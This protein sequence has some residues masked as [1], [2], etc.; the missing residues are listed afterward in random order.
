MILA[1][2]TPVTAIAAG[3][4]TDDNG[5]VHESDID[6]LASLGITRGCNPPDNDHFCPN[7]PVT[8]GQMAAFLNRALELPAGSDGEFSDTAGSVFVADINT[9]AAADITRGCNPPAN[10]RFCPNDPVTRGQ[11]AA[12]LTRA[13]QLDGN[14]DHGFSDVV[15]SPFES[16]IARIAGAG[17]TRG[18]NPPDNNR[19]CPND[20]VTR[21]QMASFLVRAVDHMTPDWSV[22]PPD[23]EIGGNNIG[24]MVAANCIHLLESST[25]EDWWGDPTSCGSAF[26]ADG[27]YFPPN[28]LD[29][30]D[31][32][33][34]CTMPAGEAVFLSATSLVCVDD[35]DAEEIDECFD[36]WWDEVGIESAFVTI[37]GI[38]IEH[39]GPH[40]SPPF[41]VTLPENNWY[42][43]P[44]GTYPAEAK[45]YA[46]V[47]IG[48]E[49]GV[50]ELHLGAVWGDGWA[51]SV[52][53]LLSVE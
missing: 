48:L 2:L 11:M 44:A 17:I 36:Y 22:L 7:D 45:A 53:V 19:F 5:S 18:C 40:S 34:E 38:E 49:P 50:H 30:G 13:L 12:F 43:A 42:E 37:D 8:R 16:D 29:E 41:D 3:Q 51:G 21:A 33:V 15:G 4:F 35:L 39:L 28:W 31:A 46:A 14:P 52:T 6:R 1:A 24:E 9:L 25:D 32:T 47:V 10:D 26:S 23:D 27:I 20:P